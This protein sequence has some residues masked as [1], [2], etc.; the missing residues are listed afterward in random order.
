M[1]TSEK[2]F[3]VIN[4]PRLGVRQGTIEF[5]PTMV[6]PEDNEISI[7]SPSKNTKLEWWV[8][9]SAP[10]YKQSVEHT[11]FMNLDCGGCTAEQ[12]VEVMYT[13]ALSLYGDY[14]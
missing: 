12:A 3:W 8:E 11:H 6:N 2:Y 7:S 1:N 9:Y 14:E 4:H 5:V 10:F 13:L